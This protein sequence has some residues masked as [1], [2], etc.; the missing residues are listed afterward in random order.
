MG[1]ISGE[2]TAVNGQQSATLNTTERPIN[3]VQR[4]SRQRRLL[5]LP[6]VGDNAAMQTE[7]P[8]RDHPRFY[9]LGIA[10]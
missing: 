5:L 4:Q 2:M 6:A 8:R 1:K 3:G 7:A 9:R 10:T